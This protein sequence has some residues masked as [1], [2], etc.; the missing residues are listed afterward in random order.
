MADQVVTRRSFMAGSVCACCVA[1]SPVRSAGA[2][3]VASA[4]GLGADGIPT[5]LE[6]GTE[7]MQRIGQTVWVENI[8]PGVWLHTTTATL[9]AGY[10]FPAN[11]LIL[12]GP[13][14]SL[15]LD[16]GYTPE[17][18]RLLVHWSKTNLSRP[19]TQAL[20]THFHGD[21]TGGI[22]A[23]KKLRI[24]TLAYPLTCRL[25]SEHQLRVP[26]PIQ[27]FRAERYRLR[28][29]CELFFPGAGHTQD[30]IVAWLP[31]QRILFGGCLLKST[32][33]NDLGYLAD[34]VVADWPDSVRRMQQR[35][36][37]PMTTIPGHGTITGDP[38]ART[39]ALLA[40]ES[41]KAAAR[42]TLVKKPA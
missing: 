3:S 2:T 36:A 13:S 41:A 14:G 22:D 21:R 32:S 29:D 34:A 11:G 27:E 5:L 25:A 7:S 16:T 23:L 37:V 42:A 12:V 19:I 15:L 9:T 40:G 24:R 18:A 10:V 26:E 30:N 31:H 17:Q 1:V 6:L 33:S 38:A 4:G 20:A 28:D 39:L 35:Y 8:A